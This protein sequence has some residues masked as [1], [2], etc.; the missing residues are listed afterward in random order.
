M[1]PLASS[2]QHKPPLVWPPRP[3]CRRTSPRTTTLCFWSILILFVAGLGYLGLL[4]FTTDTGSFHVSSSLDGHLLAGSLVVG[5]A[6]AAITAGC[7]IRHH[8]N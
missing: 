1:A 8:H 6:I 7:A 3:Q 4:A 2:P 5:C